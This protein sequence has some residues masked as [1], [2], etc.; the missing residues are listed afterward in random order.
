[1]HKLISSLFTLMLLVSAQVSAGPVDINSADADVLAEAITGIGD[2]KA[3]AIV[4]YRDA[5]G[6]FAS[7][8]DL[9]NV[10]GVGSRTI[11]KN[12]HNLTVGGSLAQ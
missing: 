3:R 4:E 1:M 12:R 7:V 8:E 9:M 5:N 6:P 10:K 11:E 2:Q